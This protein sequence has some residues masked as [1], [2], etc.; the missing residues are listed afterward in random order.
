MR[1]GYDIL[2]YILIKIYIYYLNHYVIIRIRFERNICILVFEKH[3][4]QI[5]RWFIDFLK[6]EKIAIGAL[7]KCRL[8]YNAECNKLIH[9]SG[10]KICEYAH[11]VLLLDNHDLSFR[12]RMNINQS[13]RREYIRMYSI[14][15]YFLFFHDL[16]SIILWCLIRCL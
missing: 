6:I 10:R 14:W 8:Y 11:V 9:L 1:Q 4:S 13:Q 2:K 16:L 12:G 7:L 3:L 5:T 15:K